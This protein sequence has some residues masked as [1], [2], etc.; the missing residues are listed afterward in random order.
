MADTERPEDL[1]RRIVNEVLASRGLGPDGAPLPPVVPIP[2]DEPTPPSDREDGPAVDDGQEP[3]PDATQR[4]DVSE[5][6]RQRVVRAPMPRP[7]VAP[8]GRQAEPA[9]PV[10]VDPSLPP[11]PVPPLGWEAAGLVTAAPMPP[12]VDRVAETIDEAGVVFE[13]I[14]GAAEGRKWLIAA[15]IGGVAIAVL[16]PLSIAALHVL[17]SFGN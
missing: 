15:V 11:P 5:L 13:D 4:F 12:A 2:L 3:D 16:L 1:A 8:T 7:P 6:A 10:E 14:S 9:R 17:F